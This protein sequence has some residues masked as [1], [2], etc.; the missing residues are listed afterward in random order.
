MFRTNAALASIFTQKTI[1][2]TTQSRSPRNPLI[3]VVGATG[4]GKSQVSTFSYL[5]RHKLTT[6]NNS[7]LAVEL[8]LRFNGEIINSDAMQLYDGL[9]VMTNKITEEERKSVPHHLLGCVGLNE[10]P[11]RA[12][13]FVKRAL[14]TVCALT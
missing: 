13:V 7:Q 5:R 2:T 12:D 4:T 14:E 6:T 10:Q 1:M 9:P 3:V 8:A 11:W